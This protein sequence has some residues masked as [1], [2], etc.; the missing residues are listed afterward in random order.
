MH[1]NESIPQR[2]LEFATQFF[3]GHFGESSAALVHGQKVEVWSHIRVPLRNSLILAGLTLLVFTPLCLIMATAA[4]L[5]AAKLTDHAIS[6]IT[7]IFASMPEFLVGTLVILLFFYDLKLLPPTS[8]FAG[9][10]SPFDQ[11]SEL[12][13]PVLTLLLVS[14]AFGTRL[15]RGSLVRVL[16]EDYVEAARLNGY[17]EKRIITR[18]AMRNALPPA[19]QVYA[20][21]VQ[22]LV[23]GVIIV[24]A[25]FAYPGIGTMLVQAISIRYTS[26]MVIAT[27]L[28]A[29]YIA[30]N[31]VAADIAVI[32]LVPKL[33]TEA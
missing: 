28:A 12:I 9:G 32:L 30:V 7:L 25:V 31:V 17:A 24:E 26:T 6:M 20:Q 19:M 23:G 5:R 8:A 27:L 2:Y 10:E 29:F 1:L 16:D 33:R 3:T 11:P 4:A 18:Y 22:Y 15:L 13:L 21:V 14:A